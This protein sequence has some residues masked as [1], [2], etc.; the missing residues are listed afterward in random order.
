MTSCSEG[1]EA[2][3]FPNYTTAGLG[4]YLL[5]LTLQHYALQLSVFSE[6]CAVAIQVI[7]FH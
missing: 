2:R 7:V 4:L 5:Q 3:D 6:D 1:V